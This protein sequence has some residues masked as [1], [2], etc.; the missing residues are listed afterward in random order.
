MNKSI[1]K[2]HVEA[3]HEW[4]AHTNTYLTAQSQNES[5][6]ENYDPAKHGRMNMTMEPAKLPLT[7][8]GE[9]DCAQIFE[10]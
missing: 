2:A 10:I 7:A 5:D 3:W 8:T 1:H 9:Y 4:N 6:G